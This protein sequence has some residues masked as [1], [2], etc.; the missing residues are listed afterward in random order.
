MP[1]VYLKNIGGEMMRKVTCAVAFVAVLLIMAAGVGYS[2]DRPEVAKYASVYTG[3]EGVQV[4]VL[5][6][7]PPEKSEVLLQVNRID[8]PWD[9]KIMLHKVNGTG[10]RIDYVTQVDGKDWVTMTVRDGSRELYL[11]NMEASIHLSFSEELS[12]KVAPQ[13]F[14]TLYLDQQEQIKKK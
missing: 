8:H 1:Y 6:I 4:T 12:N 9:G 10:R 5:R 3:G 13:S 14:L 7:G 2:A 11:P